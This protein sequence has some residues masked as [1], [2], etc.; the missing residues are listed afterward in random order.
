MLPNR[1]FANVEMGDRVNELSTHDLAGACRTFMDLAYPDGARTIPDFKLPY[2][3]MTGERSLVEFLPPAP[4]SV[5]V[6]K[7]LSRDLKGGG[8]FG[9]EFRL[10]CASYPHL[11]LRVQSMDLHDGEV[12][13]YSVDTHD[14]F[15]QVRQNLSDEDAQ[16][17]KAL[18]EH[19]RGL[20]HAIEQALGASGYLT[21]ITLLRIDL[22][23]PVGV[24]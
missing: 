20:K 15:R 8:M 13:V 10:G 14:G 5:G 17:W 18:V 1:L 24:S 12:W 6:T 23:A 11:K 22:S 16:K 4:L 9:Y 3:D 19:N 7:P 2:Y 21:P